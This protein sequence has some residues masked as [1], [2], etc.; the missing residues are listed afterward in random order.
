MSDWRVVTAQLERI[1]IDEI[2]YRKG[3]SHLTVVVCFEAS[4]LV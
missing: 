3:Q 4:R 1:G 2:S